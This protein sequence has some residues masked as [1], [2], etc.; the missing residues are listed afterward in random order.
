MVLQK[1]PPL[2]TD[3]LDVST[4]SQTPRSAQSCAKQLTLSELSRWYVFD[5]SKHHRVGEVGNDNSRVTPG[6]TKRLPTQRRQGC[7][8]G[9]L[10]ARPQG[11]STLPKRNSRKCTQCGGPQPRACSPHIAS[12]AQ[13]YAPAM[14]PC[15]TNSRLLVRYLG[16]QG[17]VF[18]AGRHGIP[19][20]RVRCCAGLT[21]RVPLLCAARSVYRG[22]LMKP[23]ATGW[24]AARGL[25]A[26]LSAGRS[27][28]AQPGCSF[29]P[30]PTGFL[31]T[32][33][34]WSGQPTAPTPTL[35]ASLLPAPRIALAPP[36]PLRARMFS[37]SCSWD[38]LNE[39]GSDQEVEAGPSGAATTAA[40]K[41]KAKKKKPTADVAPSAPSA[42]AAVAAADATLQSSN[43]LV[44]EVL[45]RT[46]GLKL[47]RKAV[48]TT[49]AAM[50]ESGQAY[51]D[52]E[53]VADVLLEQAG[54][55]EKKAPVRVVAFAG[56]VL[57]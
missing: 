4:P 14:A 7:F 54:L 17:R 27:T 41:R 56:S 42:T 30:P 26:G 44:E 19:C 55:L 53:A 8:R 47:T 15:E 40:K 39:D 49:I 50:F 52:A 22:L 24:H 48:E 35:P 51:D 33:H 12:Q 32:M 34:F 57:P 43:A 29:K 25:I 16:T 20:K 38:V 11:T 5:N 3:S 23:L 46:R 36:H 37:P 10:D 1:C 9:R 21:A 31:P 45:A 2:G 13:L 6:C 18:F 28:R